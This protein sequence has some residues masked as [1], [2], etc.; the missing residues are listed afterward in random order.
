MIY[1]FGMTYFKSHPLEFNF[2]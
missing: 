2:F 1:F